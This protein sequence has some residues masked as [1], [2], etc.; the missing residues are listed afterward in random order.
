LQ[1]LHI[2]RYFFIYTQGFTVMELS[3]EQIDQLQ[4]DIANAKTYDDLR[5]KDGA[6][7][8][9]SRH[10]HEFFYTLFWAVFYFGQV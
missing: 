6:I 1:C 4:R 8:R 9:R 7:K 5:G 2:E 10:L 3:K